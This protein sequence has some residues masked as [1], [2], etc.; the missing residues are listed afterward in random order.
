VEALEEGRELQRHDNDVR[1]KE[2]NILA[3]AK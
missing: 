3:H 1:R 2:K